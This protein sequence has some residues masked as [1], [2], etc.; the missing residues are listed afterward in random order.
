MFAIFVS[1]NKEEKIFKN[2]VQKKKK[3]LSTNEENACAV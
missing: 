2:W 1:K 3:E